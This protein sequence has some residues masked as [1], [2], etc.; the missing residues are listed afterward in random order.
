MKKSKFYKKTVGL[1]RCFLKDIKYFPLNFLKQNHEKSRKYDSTHCTI[2]SLT[3]R[4]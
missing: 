4:E 3:M 1:V 2:S